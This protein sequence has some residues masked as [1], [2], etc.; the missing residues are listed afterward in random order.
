MYVPKEFLIT[1]RHDLNVFLKQHSFGAF[2]MNGTA[3]FPTVTQIPFIVKELNEQLYL[4]FHIALK[5]EQASLIQEGSLGKML[6]SGAHGYISSSVYTHV[7]VPTYNYASVHVLG[8]C[9]LLS[10]EDTKLHVSELVDFFEKNRTNP[11]K[12]ENW[13]NELISAYMTEI[14]GVRLK[15][16]K[17]TGNFK[18]SQNRN[19]QDFKNILS[20]IEESNNELYNQMKQV[21]PRK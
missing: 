3:G 4:E 8:T 18:L 11:L 10:L 13:S 5:N 7:N 14:I 19:E 21:C 15:V 1:D 2:L 12:F 16:V 6:V 9:S 20:D 17:M